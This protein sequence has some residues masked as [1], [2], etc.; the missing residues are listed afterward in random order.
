MARFQSYPEPWRT[1]TNLRMYYRLA[2]SHEDDTHTNDLWPKCWTLNGTNG[3]LPLVSGDDTSA[4][5]QCLT[6]FDQYR[7]Q[8]NFQYLT[9]AQLDAARYYFEA[10][11]V[12]GF[13]WIM[14][15]DAAGT[16]ITN[17]NANASLLAAAAS[18][19]VITNPSGAFADS[20]P[21]PFGQ[22]IGSLLVDSSTIDT[23]S[24][25]TTLAVFIKG[26]APIA[27]NPPYSATAGASPRAFIVE[28]QTPG[29]SIT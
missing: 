27:D 19:L 26:L 20:A 11:P 24:P 10:L 25:A 28:A 12:G 4:S 5:F 2:M 29:Y 14:W 16:P 9:G 13:Q 17:T 21:N 23:T 15:E 8:V 3:Q 18:D 7:R 22:G 1:G 6:I